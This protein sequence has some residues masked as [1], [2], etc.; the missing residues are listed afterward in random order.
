MVDPVFTP[1]GFTYHR[2]CIMEWIHRT[3]RDP[4]QDG[5]P[6]SPTQLCPNVNL[7]DQIATWLQRQGVQT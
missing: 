2:P 1:S 5:S 7:R 6:L 4:A 3:G